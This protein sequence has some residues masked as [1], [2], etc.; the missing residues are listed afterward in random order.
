MISFFAKIFSEI[1]TIAVSIAISL[2]LMHASVQP[3][4]QIAIEPSPIMQ[5]QTVNDQ[6]KE[7]PATKTAPQKT[8]PSPASA[9]V[10]AKTPTPKPDPAVT[11]TPTPITP[12]PSSQT[13]VT[14]TPTP[15][16]VPVYIPVPVQIPS[17][18]PAPSPQ[19]A[20]EPTPVSQARL[21]VAFNSAS[22]P[23]T[24]WTVKTFKVTVTGDDG[25]IKS[26]SEAN[27]KVEATD[28][29][30][31]IT[32]N[33]IGNYLSN[34]N[35]FYYYP[36]TSGTHTITFSV[37]SYGLTK[38]V[39]FEAVSY[40]RALPRFRFN[41]SFTQVSSIDGANSGYQEVAKIRIDNPDL[42][43]QYYVRD[44]SYQ[45]ISDTLINNLL[46]GFFSYLYNLE[47]EVIAFKFNSI[48]IKNSC[49]TQ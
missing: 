20:P 43:D 13:P 46:F 18:T 7:P 11:P 1:T 25:V 28:S 8:T 9:P 24:G 32:L 23:A 27:I 2:G 40:T 49:L 3:P 19:P 21:D 10:E 29:S 34:S 31:N 42:S 35:T 15:V 33:G 36:K 17:P 22:I 26:V 41:S 4:N 47:R 39:S 45:I 44:I 14:P 48:V 12:P 30:Q 6:Q 37:P 16:Y 38:S 5:E